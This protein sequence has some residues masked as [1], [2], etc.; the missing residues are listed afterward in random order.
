VDYYEQF[1]AVEHLRKVRRRY[2][3]RAIRTVAKSS[4]HAARAG[5]RT[6]ALA[7]VLSVGVI[8]ALLWIMPHRL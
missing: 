8:S 6:A 3:I 7:A 1:L 5:G 2:L 4:R